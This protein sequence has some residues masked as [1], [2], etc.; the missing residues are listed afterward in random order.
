MK[1]YEENLKIM[2]VFNLLFYLIFNVFKYFY[3]KTNDLH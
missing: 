3:A 2:N 1:S